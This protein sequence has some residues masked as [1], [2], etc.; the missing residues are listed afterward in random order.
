MPAFHRPGGLSSG[1]HP[2]RPWLCTLGGRARVPSRPV[3]C[4]TVFRVV[5]CAVQKPPEN[6]S[7]GGRGGVSVSCVYPQRHVHWGG[8]LGQSILPPPRGVS[9]GA[10]TDSAAWLPFRF[11]FFKILMESIKKKNNKASTFRNVNTRRATQRDL[12]DSGESE[13]TRVSE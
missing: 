2:G 1:D 13:R 11:R 7:A 4:G 8:I 3:G 10:G 9:E 12:D 6:K 5:P